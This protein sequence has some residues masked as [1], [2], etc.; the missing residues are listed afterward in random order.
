LH[1]KLSILEISFDSSWYISEISVVIDACSA[2]LTTLVSARALNGTFTV[3][4]TLSNVSDSMT[5]VG[6]EFKLRYNTTLL[7]VVRVDNGTF[8]EG[9]AGS[10]NGGMLYYGPIMGPDYVQFAGL[11]L[12]DVNCTWHAPFPSGNGTI[13]TITFKVMYQPY[14]LQ[15]PTIYCNLTLFD[16]KLGDFQANPIPHDVQNSSYGIVP[17]PLGDLNFDGTTDIYDAILFATAFGTHSG[18]LRWNPYA[19]LNKDGIIDI[20]D[21]IILG[22]HFGEKRP[23]P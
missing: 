10:P 8:L 18:D 20:Y 4:I 9:F 1:R 19:D 6:V 22:R 5:L 7:Q 17:T 3:N 21:A 16:T 11:I 15:N 2:A 23:D 12:P 13:A 14:G